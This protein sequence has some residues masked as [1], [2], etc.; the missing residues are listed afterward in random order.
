MINEQII[1]FLNTL[2]LGDKGRQGSLRHLAFVIGENEYNAAKV[3]NKACVVSILSAYYRAPNR[4]AQI[5]D[6]LS[7]AER[8][9]ISLDI[10][11]D[12]SL[13]GVIA[14]EVAQEFNIAIAYNKSYY[15]YSQNGMS[16][17]KEKYVETNAKLWLLTPKSSENQL[18][19]HELRGIVGELKRNYSKV[20]SL[21]RLS[22]RENRTSDFTNI[23]RCC[24]A[25]K[26]T[27]TK[28]GIFSKASALKL[29]G[30]CG[31]EEYAAEVNRE[32]QDIRT[33]DGLLVTF[34]LSVFCHLGGLLSITESTCIP[35]S[36]AA[37][38][39]ALPYEQL[40]KK[41][42]GA[43]LKSKGFD[44]VSIMR[45]IKAKRGHTPFEARQGL[46]HELKYC[47]PGEAIYTKEFERY[48]RISAKAFARKE[49]RYIVEAGN[50]A[51]GYE[52]AWDQY[53]HP[54]IHIILT[55]FWAIGM[56]DIAWGEEADDFSDERR[57][58]PVAFRVNPLG[59][60]VLDLADSYTAPIAPRV[61]I[62]GGFTL[63]PDYTIVVSDS[64][65]RLKHELYF[66]KLFTKISVT[67]QTSIYRL[68]FATVVRAIDG[69]VSIK[70]LRRYLS[71]SDRPIPE[72]IACAL[73]DWE[74]Q[75]GRI[76]LRQVTILECDDAPLLE[77]VIRYKGMGEFIQEK[78][79]AAVVVNHDA[80]GKI[81]KAIEKNGRF[82]LDVI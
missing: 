82:C 53:E 58:I 13:P 35:G 21:L 42:F 81:K 66:E 44:E 52:A 34:P 5:W 74:K 19:Y 56:V 73:N 63:L 11:S 23:I 33:A 20:P 32:P 24:N 79:A 61:K 2:Q 57:R 43:Y 72:N 76:R 45:G 55:F 25:N 15:A 68:D 62:Q 31:Y 65:N 16:S 4:I 70:D 9:I 67:E 46:V 71:A 38:L 80:T 3:A 22:T 37:F 12:G 78:I 29:C 17:F 27:V 18:L 48:L 36:K 7:D 14:D 6:S 41:L 8:K 51:Y 69:G 60:Y 39:L 1:D 40:V 30:Y 59:A 64:S 10:W 26:V 28:S 49:D 50:S 77:E 47:Q 54:L 75:V